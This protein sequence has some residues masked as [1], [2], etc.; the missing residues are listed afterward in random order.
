MLKLGSDFVNSAVAIVHY[1][2]YS[3]YLFLFCVVNI[4]FHLSV[5]HCCNIFSLFMW[6]SFRISKYS[7]LVAVNNC[8]DRRIFYHINAAT[9]PLFLII[10]ST[11]TVTTY[12]RLITMSHLTSFLLLSVMI[13]AVVA[14]SVPAASS[15]NGDTRKR[16]SQ[17][18]DQTEQLLWKKFFFQG[19]DYKVTNWLLCDQM[20]A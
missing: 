9:S 2:R 19:L 13:L 3:N 15:A 8:D 11:F 16:H 20:I 4:L 6:L 12:Y 1:L 14:N 17:I 7:N 10:V 5:F 18:V